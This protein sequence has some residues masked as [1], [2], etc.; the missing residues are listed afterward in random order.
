MKQKIQQLETT[1][2]GQPTISPND[3]NITRLA[4]HLT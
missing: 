3:N 1:S 2:L 4:Y